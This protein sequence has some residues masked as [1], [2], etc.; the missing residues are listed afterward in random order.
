MG[1]DAARVWREAERAE[2]TIDRETGELR[3]KKG[4]QIA[5]HM[6]IALPREAT[7]EQRQAMLL[8]F[9]AREIAAAEAWRRGGMGDPSRGE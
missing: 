3:W 5:K 8:A 2:Q 6:T 1:G 7:A 9:I 4:G